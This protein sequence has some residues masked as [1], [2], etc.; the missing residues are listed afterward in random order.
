MNLLFIL[1]LF[2]CFCFLFYGINC[3]F[4]PQMKEEFKRFNLSDN[5]RVLTGILQILGSFGLLI[6]WYFYPV[7]FIIS[8]SGL[9]LLMLIGFFVRLKIEDSLYVSFPS[10]FFS[11]INFFLCLSYFKQVF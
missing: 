5:Q 11:I 4:Y 10:L 3:L 7:L 9:A 8:S 6:G 2:I 1:T